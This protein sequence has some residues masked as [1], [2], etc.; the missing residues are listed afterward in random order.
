[1]VNYSIVVYGVCSAVSVCIGITCEYTVPLYVDCALTLQIMALKYC[2]MC[3]VQFS[4]CL[5]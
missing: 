1:M 4:H 3:L 2:V 5:Q